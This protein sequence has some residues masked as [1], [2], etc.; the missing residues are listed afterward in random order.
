MW[1]Y[2]HAIFSTSSPISIW[3]LYQDISKWSKWD[4]EII[5]AHLEGPFTTG[6]I[7]TLRVLNQKTNNFILKEVKENQRFTNVRKVKTND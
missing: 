7:G 2:E 5:E 3:N 4:N 6:S 1:N